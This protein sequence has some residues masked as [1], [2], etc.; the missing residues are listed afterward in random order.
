MKHEY[1]KWFLENIIDKEF[2]QIDLPYRQYSRKYEYYNFDRHEVP[3]DS[4]FEKYLI[5]FV[6]TNDFEYDC[7][8]IH[9]WGVGSYFDEHIDERVNRKIVYV[10]ELQESKCKTKLIVENKEKEEDWF[11]IYTNHTVPK[12]KEGER[13]SLTVFGKNKTKTII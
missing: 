5:Q 3:F 6:Q 8:H 4:D 13:I 12:I 7:Y 1:K 9:K 2:T 10:C 11:G